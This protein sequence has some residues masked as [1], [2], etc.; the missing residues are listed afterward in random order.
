MG[1]DTY[2]TLPNTNAKGKFKCCHMTQKSNPTI[3]PQ[4]NKIETT[5]D[6]LRKHGVGSEFIIFWWTQRIRK[7]TRHS[8][9]ISANRKWW[10]FH[11]RGEIEVGRC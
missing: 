5:L 9:W 2:P 8:V 7:R 1:T 10:K 3:A 4:T 6:D 11:V